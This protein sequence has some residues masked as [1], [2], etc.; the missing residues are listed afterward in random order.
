MSQSFSVPTPQL[1]D[2]V[3]QDVET[4]DVAEVTVTTDR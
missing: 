4:E 2:R 1:C 3:V